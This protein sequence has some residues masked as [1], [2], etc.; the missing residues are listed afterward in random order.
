MN[1]QQYMEIAHGEAILERLRS[2]RAERQAVKANATANTTSHDTVTVLRAIVEEVSGVRPP[3]STDSY[4][5][6][7]L[8]HDA[9]LAIERYEREQDASQ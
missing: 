5:P 7:H 1:S 3:F 2:M 9:R 8:I 4:L 6:A